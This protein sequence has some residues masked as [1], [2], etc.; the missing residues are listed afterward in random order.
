[1]VIGKQ[2]SQLRKVDES[3]SLALEL[4]CRKKYCGMNTSRG[5]NLLRARSSNFDKSD[6][7]P[8]DSKKVL[9][10]AIKMNIK[11]AHA[12]LGHSNEDTT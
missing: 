12:I 6:N 9:K 4:K 8:A 2:G 1:M 3:S 11:R 5:T 7:Q 10:S